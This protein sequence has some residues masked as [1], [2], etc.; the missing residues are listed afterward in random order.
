MLGAQAVLTE[1]QAGEPGAAAP[2]VVAHLTAENERL[3]A[4]NQHAWRQVADLKGFLNDYGLV[5]VG[6]DEAGGRV[7]EAL[8]SGQSDGR[9]TGNGRGPA[10]GRSEFNSTPSVS[11]A[12]KVSAPPGAPPSNLRVRNQ[13]S[14]GGSAVSRPS[15]A[16]GRPQVLSSINLTPHEGPSSLNETPNLN[17]LAALKARQRTAHT[18]SSSSATDSAINADMGPHG[19]GPSAHAGG[20]GGS[21]Q[22]DAAMYFNS[23]DGDGLPEATFKVYVNAPPQG[24]PAPA[25]S[26]AGDEAASE[27]RSAESVHQPTPRARPS[28]SA[29]PSMLSQLQQY[30]QVQVRRCW[31][32]GVTRVCFVFSVERL[33][34]ASIFAVER[35]Q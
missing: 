4:Q 7:E 12:A 13:L 14:G 25:P 11:M 20:G 22:Q 33:Q 35:L 26:S 31:L 34:K 3:S 8:I 27:S 32:G 30:S 21:N 15:S 17:P 23:E 10:G 18:S 28:S 19:P 1:Q 2:G 24:A 5:W 16:R 9:V 6:E 29:V